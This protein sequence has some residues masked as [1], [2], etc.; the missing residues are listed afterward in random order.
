MT[1]RQQRA[2]RKQWKQWNARRAAERQCSEDERENDESSD[3]RVVN[4]SVDTSAVSSSSQTPS[5]SRM[6]S[7]QAVRG[8]K[9]KLRDRSPAY[10][11][12]DKLETEVLKLKR[13][14]DK[15]RKR[16]ERAKLGKRLRDSD[17]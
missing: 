11:Q 10:R 6:P 17:P 4:V 9:E 14:C 3:L 13:S 15:F 2:K 8:R 5:S 16:A 1:L 12:I 7:R